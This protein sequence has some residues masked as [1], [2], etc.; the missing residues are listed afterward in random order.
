MKA[1]RVLRFGLPN[2]RDAILEADGAM[3][4]SALGDI[5]HLHCAE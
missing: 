3:E 4:H 1:A 5:V 2:V